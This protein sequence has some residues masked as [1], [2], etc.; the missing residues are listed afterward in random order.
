ML[1]RRRRFVHH[2]DWRTSLW[3]ALDHGGAAT[4]A[5]ELFFVLGL[6]NVVVSLLECER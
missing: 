6:V 2:L 5:L 4:R 3:G 1:L